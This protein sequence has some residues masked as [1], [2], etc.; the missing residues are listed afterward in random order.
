MTSPLF[1]IGHS[2]HTIER[3]LD[4]LRCHHV[5]AVADVRSSPFCRYTTQFNQADLKRSLKEAGIHY[6]YL[7]RELGA[8]STDPGHYRDGKARYDLIAQTP[9]FIAG[10]ERLRK[11]A[12]TQRI[13]LMC[14]E[15]E[16]LECHR[17]LLVGVRL[18]SAEITLSHILA[19]GGLEPHEHTEQRML[20]I[21]NLAEPELFRTAAERL[22]EAYRRQ[23]ERIEYEEDHVAA[24]Q[25]GASA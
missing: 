15:K 8:R 1:T 9:W 10:I 21:H 22:A 7:G 14:A 11:G 13:A 6:A 4:L 23:C 2:N 19:D 20:R 18:R 5:T 12:A 16:P 24:E 17:T 3:F 25:Q